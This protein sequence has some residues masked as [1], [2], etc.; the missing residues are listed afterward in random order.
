MT[1]PLKHC[2]LV[3]KGGITSGVVYPRAVIELSKKYRFDNIGGTSAGAIAAVVTA[4]AEYG[5][6]SGGFDKVGKLPDELSKTLLQKFQPLPHLRPLFALLLAALTKRWAAVLIALLTGYSKSA[7]LGALPGL[8][9]LVLA[10][11]SQESG[12]GVLG[13]LLTLAGGLAAPVYSAV[14]QVTGAL[15]EADFGLCSGLTQPDT[16]GPALTDWLADTIDRVAGL[17]PGAP[18]LG[19]AKLLERG[20]RVNTVTTDISTHRPYALPM[21]NRLHFFSEREFRRLFPKRI[22][23]SMVA[24]SKRVE[25]KDKS[26]DLYYFNVE[27]MPLVVMARMSLS[28]P[29]LISAVPLWRYDYTL[30]NASDDQKLVRCL[31]SDGGLSSNFPVHFFDRFLP[32]TPTFG[33][34]LGEHN[35]LRTKTGD[36]RIVLPLEAIQGQLLPTR[37]IKGIFGF[38]MALFGSAKDWQDSLQSIL[39]GYRER[40]VTVNLTEDEGGLN[41][42]M[43]GE[44]IRDLTRYGELAGQEIVGKFCLDE[45]RWRRYLVEI[46]AIDD[47]LRDFAK[48]Y[49]AEPQPGSMAYAELAVKYAPHSFGELTRAERKA[50]K[51]KAE[52][53]AELGRVLAGLKPFHDMDKRLPKSRS[54]LRSIARMDDD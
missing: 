5:R 26:R 7:V 21:G 13:L 14:R 29:G 2:D 34:S 43:P 53:I 31:F 22:V 18:P 6:D 11:Y 36:D 12:Y 38:I 17:A 9:T 32:Q 1:M 27:N 35:P 4:A 50:I 28:F 46:R 39:P 16:D 8:V 37:G 40:I 24:A 19:I 51:D 10:L 15:P 42:D 41:L 23:D 3:M 54:R 44:R 52:R 33:I 20:I 48:A 45:H 49:D 47:M 25:T 30:I